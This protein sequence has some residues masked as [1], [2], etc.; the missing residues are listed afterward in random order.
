M[1]KAV[2]LFS[3]GL[4]SILAVKLVE[5]QGVEVIPLHFYTWFTGNNSRRFVEECQ[6]NYGISPKIID[7]Q[8]EFLD[9]LFSPKYGYGQGM[10]PCID[11]KIFFFR[12]AKE[13]METLGASFVV[14]GEVIGQRPMSQKKDALKIIE[15]ESGL[16]GLILR[17]LCAKLLP[18]TIPEKKGW[19]DRERLE[20]IQGR[21]R[22]RQL[23]LAREFGLKHIP[24]PAGGCILTD[25][26]FST[27]LKALMEI[28]PKPDLDQIKLLR[29]GRL[30]RVGDCLVV[31]SRTPKEAEK[32]SQAKNAWILENISVSAVCFGNCKDKMEIVA[33][34]LL[35]Y[36]KL[37]R[38]RV[39]TPEG[40]ITAAAL[41]PEEVH[42]YLVGG[43]V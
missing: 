1:P 2:A 22:K 29:L 8:E 14:S 41:A 43:S 37:P 20:A 31:V 27:R 35:R 34:I 17:P 12:K 30:F 32:L 16:E 21:G 23:E 5:S 3:G 13:L 18:E 42:R 26:T 11:C 25:P 4:D 28:S 36:G 19:V 38:G 33:G 40:A 10:N 6:K 24:S 9:I 15:K 7:L 39:L